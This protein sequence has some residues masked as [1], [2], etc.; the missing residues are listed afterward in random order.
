M[1]LILLAVLTSMTLST[2][3]RITTC[4]TKRGSLARVAE[5]ESGSREA[6]LG[7]VVSGPFTLQGRYDAVTTC[8]LLPDNRGSLLALT[9]P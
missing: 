7:L 1:L 8:G 2:D 4:S 5:D 9:V 6:L 3:L